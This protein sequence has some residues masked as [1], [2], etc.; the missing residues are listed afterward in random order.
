MDGCPIMAKL[1]EEHGILLMAIL[2]TICY[3]TST[4]E[5]D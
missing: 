3:S 5:G 4:G 1:Q 2:I